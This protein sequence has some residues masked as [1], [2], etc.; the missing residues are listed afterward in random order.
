MQERSSDSGIRAYLE[1]FDTT[2][3]PT[4]SEAEAFGPYVLCDLFSRACLY[5]R[6]RAR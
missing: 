3:A 1:A 6:Y 4:L 5:Q 2:L